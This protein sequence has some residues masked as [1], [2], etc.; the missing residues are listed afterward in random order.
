MTTPSH[1]P[2][3]VAHLATQH[4]WKTDRIIPNVVSREYETAVGMKQAS[5]WLTVCRETQ[6]IYLKP[7]YRSEGRNAAE[8]TIGF[9]RA[10]STEAEA[11]A[12]LDAYLPKLDDCIAQTYA[13]RLFRLGVTA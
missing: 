9:I 6:N 5:I 1:V 2:A 12:A 3:L 11:L 13:A 8:S 4:G 7:D 10:A